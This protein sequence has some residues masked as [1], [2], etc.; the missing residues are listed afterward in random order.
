MAIGQFAETFDGGAAANAVAVGVRSFSNGVNSTSLGTAAN[1][2]GANSQAFGASA[3]S[4]GTN[5]TAIGSNASAI[6]TNAYASGANAY[7]EG[8]NVIA[9]GANSYAYGYQT[10]VI[11]IGTDSSATGTNVTAIGAGA[12]AFGINATA[13]GPGANAGTYGSTA[14]GAGAYTWRPNQIVLGTSGSNYQMPGLGGI[15]GQFIN[16][17]YQNSGE[18]RFVTTDSQGTLGTTSFS[19]QQM[20]SS[21]QGI[22]ASSAALTSTPQVTLLPEETIRC[23]VGSGMYGAAAAVSLGCAVR[24]KDRIFFNGGIASAFRDQIFGSVSGKV[25]VS[26]GWGGV[27][28]SKKKATPEGTVPTEGGSGSP[29]ILAAYKQ[30]QLELN[31]KQQTEIE[32]LQQRIKQLES[33]L[34]SYIQKAKQE[35]ERSLQLDGTVAH[36]PDAQTIQNLRGMLNQKERLEQ[37][38]HQQLQAQQQDLAMQRLMLQQ[39]QHQIN[40]LIKL[41][42]PDT[43]KQITPFTMPQATQAAPSTQPSGKTLPAVSLRR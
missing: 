40:Q 28:A 34:I 33:E 25:G 43:A 24:A 7:A 5:T 36:K 26:I 27:P 18:K 38:L 2:N 6:G 37:Q 3:A 22:A 23:G 14:I 1:A 21:I 10:N 15:N 19:V 11:A 42:N 41:L 17:T 29:V 13:I 8:R 30:E 4:S 9:I 16:D 39:Q 20:V 35:K 31:K 12:L 32:S